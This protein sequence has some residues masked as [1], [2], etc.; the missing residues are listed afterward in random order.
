MRSKGIVFA[1]L[2]LWISSSSFAHADS[3]LPANGRLVQL[4][5]IPDYEEG[6]IQFDGTASYLD[7]SPV[8]VNLTGLP[9]QVEKEWK[10]ETGKTWN[11]IGRI[12]DGRIVHDPKKH[13]YHLLI[14]PI[15]LQPQ[16][17]L[18][19]TF[20]FINLDYGQ[21]SPPPDPQDQSDEIWRRFAHRFSYKAG[22][23]DRDI[24]FLD[25]PFT[26]I[27]KQIDLILTPLMGE[28]L[29]GK[30][31]GLRL[32]GRVSFES[33]EDYEE[34]SRHCQNTSN[35]L[36]YGDYRIAH[37]LSFLDYPHYSGF[38]AI[39]PAYQF[40]PTTVALRS[41]L[42]A[43]QYDRGEGI[44]SVAATFSGRAVRWGQNE[45]SFPQSLQ[46]TDRTDGNYLF[47][48][49]LPFK[50]VQGYDIWLGK[51]VL[52]P[53]DVLTI[54]VPHVQMQADALEPPPTTMIYPG[55]DQI[56][57]QPQIVYHGPRTFD[58]SVKYVPQTQLFL[59][60][61][62]AI[63]RPS[64]ALVERQFGS[65]FGNAG[66]LMTWIILAL[67]FLLLI[68]SKSI[69]RGRNWLGLSAWFLGSVSLLY[70]LRGSFGLLVI[71]LAMYLS[72]AIL[73]QPAPAATLSVVKELAKGLAGVSLIAVAIILDGEGTRL[74]RDLST[75]DLSPLTPVILVILTGTMLF[76]LYGW[77]RDT[78]LF[79][80]ADLPTLALFLVILCTYDALDKSLLALL[81]VS[82]GGVYVLRR[83]S[84]LRE[85]KSINP[86]THFGEGLQKRLEL[87]FANR[88]IPLSI[89]ALIV[90]AVGN[91][92]TSTYSSELYVAVPW[93]VA[94]LLPPLLV[95]ASVALTFTSIALLFILLYPVIP[96]EAGYI[97]AAIFALFLFLV[98]L[99]GLGTDDRLIA[100]LQTILVGRVIYYLSVP[101]LI[102][103][104]FDI[105]DF[106]Q[107]ENQRRVAAGEPK[108]E[109]N[110]QSASTMYF[111]RLQGIA[112][113][114]AGILSLA[115]PSVYAFLSNQPVIVTYFNL[116]EKLVLLP[117]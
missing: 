44:G 84:R 75:S 85:N 38:A 33:L 8:P 13:V 79:K 34:F 31:D 49:L 43:C 35:R 16:D 117:V 29:V 73:P 115:A 4:T 63:L 94:P 83:L 88:L 71:A 47:D 116:L 99:F 108:E 5:L 54:T 111:K 45:G 113:A 89:L 86:Q 24:P 53:G 76:L 92:L 68:A 27:E 97:K 25:I 52:A 69:N 114:L 39:N 80:T 20:P 3:A 50:G 95:F 22:G 30:T 1:T 87:A 6:T 42:L 91:D 98:F 21:I 55:S 101:M 19:F 64:I 32:S 15:S 41:E 90:L 104:Y 96:F 102:G 56:D 9:L 14:G 48:P 65:L 17:E 74:F 103:V 51:L 60:Q 37:L 110:F 18:R 58:L 23:A 106:M 105:H 46:G 78:K 100:S 67:G 40:K 2:I 59:S 12:K 112:G 36:K 77:R 7:Y 66:A 70:G 107:R 61:V 82:L 26:P 10:D 72:Q 62:P 81:M 11:I 28:V 109:I 57:Q 93:I